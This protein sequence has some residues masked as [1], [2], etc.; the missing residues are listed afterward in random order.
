MPVLAPQYNPQ[1]QSSGLTSKR[2]IAGLDAGASLMDR[3]QARRLK[4]EENERRRAEFILKLPVVAATA[5]ADRA[6]ALNAYSSAINDQVNRKDAYQLYGTAKSEIDAAMKIVDAKERAAASRQ[7]LGK[8]AQLANISEIEG[9]MKVLT[10]LA[11]SNVT[12]LMK[13]NMLTSAEMRTFEGLTEEMTPEEKAQAARVKLGLRGRQSGAAIQYKEVVGPDGRPILV[14]VDPRAVGAQVVG[15]GQRYGTGVDSAQPPVAAGAPGTDVFAGQTAGEK[16]TQEAEAQYQADLK[17]NKPKRQA[18][19]EQAQLSS[20]RLV[21]EIDKLIGEVNIVT[22]GPGGVL[23]NRFPGTTARDLTANLDAIKSVI[24]F[25]ALQ[26]MRDA[27][28]TGGALGPVSDFENKLLQAQ[29]GNLEIGQ[30]PSQLIENL[31]KVKQRV[32]ENVGITRAFFANEYADKPT[33][34][35]AAPDLKTMTTEQLEQ[36]LQELR[37]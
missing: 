25:Q 20:D 6:K 17:K 4:E 1:D 3:A 19:L 28:P 26:A 10:N 36:R 30:S 9:E 15:G 18:S 14:A 5:E 2:F 29:L 12:D 35:A 11:T 7:W 34:D 31:K 13:I 33:A 32:G 21:S 37:R 22:A 16:K 27:S 8:Y 23:L 24:G